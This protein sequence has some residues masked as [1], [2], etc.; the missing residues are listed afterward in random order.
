MSWTGHCTNELDDV[1]RL[2]V[3]PSDFRGERKGERWK[4]LADISLGPNSICYS[5]HL[6]NC[7]ASQMDIC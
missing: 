5:F 3:S 4:R 7:D 1:T 2:L 6:P